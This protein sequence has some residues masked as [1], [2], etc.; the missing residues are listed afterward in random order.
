MAKGDSRI[1]IE[2]EGG[3]VRTVW[4]PDPDNSVTVIDH[5]ILEDGDAVE[6]A[7]Y[8]ELVRELDRLRDEGEVGEIY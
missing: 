5:D 1:F 7:G 8:K 4:G 3:L 6:L 2:M